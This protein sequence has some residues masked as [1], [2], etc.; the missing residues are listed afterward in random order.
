MKVPLLDLKAQHAPLMTEIR[1]AIDRVLTAQRF[2]LGPEVEALEQELAKYCGVKRAVAV[3][4]GSDAIVATLMAMGIGAGDE[5]IVPTF[6]FFATAGAV[7][8]VGARPVFVDIHPD[9]FN[10]DP[11]AIAAAVTQRTRAVIPVHLYGQCA[12][13]KKIMSVAKKHGLAVIEDAAQAIGATHR[14]KPVGALGHAATLSFYPT[15]NL[16]AIG[17]AGMILT[18]DEKLAEKLRHLRDHG[19]NPQYHH[20]LIGG[21]FRMDAIQG[22]VLRVKLPRLNEWSDARRRH[23]ARYNEA[24]K[25]SKVIPPAVDEQARHVYHQ[26]TIRSARRDALRQCLTEAEIAS[27]IYYP[28]P[29]HLQECFADLGYERGECPVAE[30]AADEVLSLPIFPEMTEQQQEHVI[31]TIQRFG[32]G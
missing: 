26:Y 32:K 13:M 15:K 24:F 11:A 16:S 3:S 20:H 6:T 31:S 23:A 28:I 30:K 25:N 22:A 14:D 7:A 19:Q 9:T 2:I 10:I 27:G 18:N 5:V 21:N 29:L 17:E 12:D 8:R 4:N 1:A